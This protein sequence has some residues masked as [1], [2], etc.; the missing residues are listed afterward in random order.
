MVVLNGWNL[1]YVDLC[2]QS[3]VTKFTELVQSPRPIS[4][5]QELLLQVC[6][7]RP[8]PPWSRNHDSCG[9]Y[10]IAAVSRFVPCQ[11]RILPLHLCSCHWYV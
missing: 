9:Q 10:H 11:F 3:D 4:E 6:V 2:S 1:F 8:D 5:K 7:M